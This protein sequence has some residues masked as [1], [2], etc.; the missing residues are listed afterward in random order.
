MMMSDTAMDE[1]DAMDVMDVNTRQ[2]TCK[3]RQ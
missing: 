1:I 2:R 3:G